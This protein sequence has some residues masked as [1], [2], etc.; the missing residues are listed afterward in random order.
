M[1]V[2]VIA[3]VNGV[4]AG[5][6]AN[7]ALGCDLVLAAR[8]ASFIQAFSKI[9]LVPDCGG[10]WLLPRLVG[11]RARWA[12]DARRQAAGRGGRAHR[13]DLAVRR[14]RGADGRRRWRWPAAGRDADARRWPRRGARI[15]AAMALDFGDAL[16]TGGRHAARARPRRTTTREG[17]AAFLA[18]RAA[19]VHR[20]LMHADCDATAGIAEAARD[21]M[22]RE[23]PR[24]ARRSGMQVLAVGPGT[25]DAGDDGA[26]RHAQRP[27]HLPRRPD[28]HAGRHRLRLRLQRL[29]RGH[30]GRRASTST[31][32]PRRGW[33]TC[34][35]RRAQRGAQ[36]RPHGVYDIAVTQPARRGGGGCSAAARTR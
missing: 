8:T 10:T 21:A 33:A 3:A 29:Q 31:C 25:R 30:R 26:R 35:P 23:R 15:D 12:G 27:R 5:A 17:V 7:L 6:G 4:A 1:P 34:S 24:V 18:K 9:G 11:R 16:S 19:A 32:S 13:P 36:G 28:L 20:P 22:W 14:R 2:P